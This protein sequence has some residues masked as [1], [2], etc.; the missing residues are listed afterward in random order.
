M[1]SVPPQPESTEHHNIVEEA[2]TVFA[3]GV[4]LV[5]IVTIVVVF[6]SKKERG[7]RPLIKGKDIIGCQFGFKSHFPR[8]RPRHVVPIGT[9]A[10]VEP[11]V[12][13]ATDK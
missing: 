11:S 13:E 4:M 6:F 3:V 1:P 12:P 10:L 7:G 2:G 9:S 5:I 8:L